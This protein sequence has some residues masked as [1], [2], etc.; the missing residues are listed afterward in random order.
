[1]WL[2]KLVYKKKQFLMVGLILLVTS[3]VLTTCVAF[4]MELNT[5]ADKSFTEENSPDIYLI[6]QNADK[7]DGYLTDQA[8][9]DNI[10]E[11][12][13]L[14][15]ILLDVP[16]K[17]GDVNFTGIYD[18][19]TSGKDMQTFIDHNYVTID[20]GSSQLPKEGEVWL[21]KTQAFNNNIKVGD[22][23]S[24]EYAD[25]EKLTVT[26][27][28]NTTAFPK[29][30]GV[31]M[32][33]VNQKLLDQHTDSKIGG[34]IA[35]KLIDNSKEKQNELAK[36]FPYTVMQL[37]RAALKTAITDVSGVIG[38]I[39]IVA[40]FIVFFLALAVIR[41]IIRT[42]LIKEYRSVGIYKSMGYSSKE[43]I[44]I[45]RNGYLLVGIIAQLIG[46][47]ASLPLVYIICKS[48]T[49]C[50]SGFHLTGL[51]VVACV[52]IAILLELVLWLSVRMALNRLK[53][54]T[55]VQA[56]TE[57]LNAGESRLRK[58]MIKDGKSSFAMALNEIIRYW[59]QS[60]T[61]LLVLTVSILLS[62]LF[63]QGYYSC[64]R[65]DANCNGWFSMAKGNA[66]VT[67]LINN[68][69]IDY[70]K[71]SD[72]VQ[73]FSYGN[74]IYTGD[75]TAK[76]YEEDELQLIVLNDTSEAVTGIRAWT[77][78]MPQNDDEIS[79]SK[80][81]A[82]MMGVSAGDYIT[83]TM[84]GKNLEYLVT[85]TFG[86]MNGG[87]NFIVAM[88]TENALKKN[89]TDFQ[90][91][92]ANVT[93]KNGVDFKEFKTSMENAM[94]GISVDEKYNA[95]QTAVRSIEKMLL[96]IFTI[97]IIVFVSFAA[98]NVINVLQMQMTNNRRQYGI[99]KAMGFTSG[100]MI[101]QNLWKFMLLTS[102]SSA[103]ATAIHYAAFIKVM[104]SFLG[105]YGFSNDTLAS[106][107]LI[108]G[109]H[110]LVFIVTILLSI[111][112]KKIKPKELMEQ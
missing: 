86:T 9:L 96:S 88:M 102:V 19:M 14:S 70:L 85:G 65:M 12:K 112:I 45:Y 47:F 30:M 63:V 17:C 93:L 40:A 71:N 104:D 32:I 20:E 97:L 111:P 74:P 39:G 68:E 42:S 94:N 105:V 34:L 38:S 29:S 2:K 78:R 66:V 52:G 22:I 53:S 110:L 100:Y 43:I 90:P 91:V 81:T 15:S 98:I 69:T 99:M 75:I 83:F 106:V 33:V 73:S 36:A 46:S 18:F 16:L 61:I 31:G 51:S 87:P 21:S 25:A 82:S 6:S 72:K 10:K 26:A 1:M 56:I 48:S 109:V 79:L 44:K 64:D 7:L 107:M 103:I 27:I 58:S 92:L 89:V 62:Y 59:K 3:M 35:V 67:G 55:P 77:G 8:V 84:K 95:L 37:N 4:L 23:I 49:E 11:S 28:Y 57:G 54:I 76:G 101:R 60:V 41:Y 80:A 5:F 108:L 13:S 24:L 50:I